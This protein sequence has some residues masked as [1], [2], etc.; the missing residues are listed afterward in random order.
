MMPL[1][2]ESPRQS[3]KQHQSEE[4]AGVF[5]D[6]WENKGLEE[7]CWEVCLQDTEEARCGGVV[8]G[9]EGKP[10]GGLAS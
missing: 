9:R 1:G 5:W 10:K 3:L 7:S 6:N 2:V 8:G 4:Q